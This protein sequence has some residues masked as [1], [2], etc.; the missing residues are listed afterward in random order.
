MFD[1]QRRAWQQRL[2]CGSQ[3]GTADSARKQGYAQLF[4]EQA[5]RF[6]DGCLGDAHRPCGGTDAAESR[7]ADEREDL[8]ILHWVTT[9]G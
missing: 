6:R 5:H 2:A 4:F 7:D 3:D 8:R 1:D 9:Y